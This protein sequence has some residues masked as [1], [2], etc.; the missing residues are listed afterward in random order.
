MVL[1]RVTISVELVDEHSERVLWAVEETVQRNSGDN[2]FYH[3][4]D[5]KIAMD[6]AVRNVDDVIK[7]RFGSPPQE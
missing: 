1:K 2:P 4:V 3:S 6:A 5:A 7:H